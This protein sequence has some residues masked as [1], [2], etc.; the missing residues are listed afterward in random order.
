[1]RGENVWCVMIPRGAD[2]RLFVPREGPALLQGLAICGRCGNPM[3]VRYH[4]RRGGVSPDYVC[5]GLRSTLWH[6]APGA[7]SVRV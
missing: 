4:A 5:D 2:R 6:R 1:M 7:A 3:S